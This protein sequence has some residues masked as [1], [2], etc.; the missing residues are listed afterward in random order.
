MPVVLSPRQQHVTLP[1]FL[2]CDC[3]SFPIAYL[4]FLLW[5]PV[6]QK[7]YHE[8]RNV[9]DDGGRSRESVDRHDRSTTYSWV[10]P[11]LKTI[12]SAEK[13]TNNTDATISRRDVYKRIQFDGCG[14]ILL[15]SGASGSTTSLQH[16]G[17]SLWSA[18]YVICN[19]SLYRCFVE[20]RDYE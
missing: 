1:P 3:S 15:H 2:P 17:L 13:K 10:N 4:R 11:K 7:G 19:V 16:T 14:S 9:A 5:R 20:P 8:L 12:I 6:A 18:A